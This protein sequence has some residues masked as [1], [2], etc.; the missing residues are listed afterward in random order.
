[1]QFK[2]KSATVVILSNNSDHVSTDRLTLV[3]LQVGD[4]RVFSSWETAEPFFKENDA[5]LAL[6]DD[7]SDLG[8]VQCAKKLRQV[9][10]NRLIPIVM[11]TQEN[12]REQ[13]LDAISAGC[14]GY[15]LRPYA[16][17]T[18]YKHLQVAIES[19]SYDEIENEVLNSAK[20][21]V[22][23]GMFDEA[24]EEFDE[25]VS[26]ENESQKYFNMGMD[27]LAEEKYGKAI[28]SFNKAL[29]INEMFAEACKGI[30]DAYKGKGD[31]TNF[32]KYL[33]KAAD[34]YASQ[35]RLEKTKELFV[36][37][38]KADPDAVNPYNSLGVKL[39][40]KGDYFGALHAYGQA[41]SITPDDENLH[42]N[43]AKA[44]LFSSS[45]DKAIQHLIRSLEINPELHHARELLEKIRSSQWKKISEK[46]AAQPTV[47]K[48][49][50]TVDS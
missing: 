33:T 34:I 10:T 26:D 42:F 27:Y 4:I 23:R 13:V 11:V 9:S 7:L 29:K 30:A 28:I 36:E 25:I 15:V 49:G 2:F 20:L 38:L 17:G 24:I 44:H 50:M 8:G 48:D 3:E 22:E 41:L 43:I 40:R 5:D 1:M 46:I 14:G 37:I 45:K 21:L 47:N 32:Q 39:R 6:V 12:R 16:M 18:V 31:G 19:S 35:D